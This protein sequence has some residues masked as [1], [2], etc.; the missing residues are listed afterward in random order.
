M[1]NIRIEG[2][3]IKELD[4]KR[5]F[6]Q[7]VTDAATKCYGLAREKIVVVIAE[8]SPENVSV[9]GQLLVDRHKSVPD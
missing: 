5:R 8:N 6:V 1:P 4:R 3:P 7:E 9:G 2:P